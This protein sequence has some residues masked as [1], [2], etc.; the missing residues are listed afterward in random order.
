MTDWAQV[1]DDYLQ[2]LE[3]VWVALEQVEGTDRLVLRSSEGR[4]RSE[5]VGT[6]RYWARKY[7][8]GN[9]KGITMFVG[10][11]DDLVKVT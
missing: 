10:R 9:R 7:K 4:P 1:V 8:R 5:A 11:I 2:Y 3:P 6:A